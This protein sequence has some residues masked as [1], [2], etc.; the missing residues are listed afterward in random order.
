[1]RLDLPS[2]FVSIGRRHAIIV[3]GFTVFV[4]AQTVTA[5]KSN[6]L[7]ESVIQNGDQVHFHGHVR[8]AACSIV[9]AD[10]ATSRGGTE[11]DLS[12][13]VHMKLTI[14]IDPLK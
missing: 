8:I 12:G 11:V 9:T 2:A 14:G 1:V 5:P 3:T 10:D 7:A 4:G 13:N 6:W